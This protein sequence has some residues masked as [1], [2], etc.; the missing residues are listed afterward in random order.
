MES[1]LKRMKITI[2]TGGKSFL[3]RGRWLQHLQSMVGR[4]GLGQLVCGVSK[5]WVGRE[6][7]KS[8][9]Q[10]EDVR[11]Y[12]LAS[13]RGYCQC[14]APEFQGF[15]QLVVNSLRLLVRSSSGDSIFFFLDLQ[16][17]IFV[18][19]RGLLFL[20]SLCLPFSTICILCVPL[21]ST[22]QSLYLFYLSKN[23]IKKQNPSN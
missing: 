11:I 13:L 5:E 15:G 22:F 7:G 12:P 17:Y 20:F 14:H 18:L 21:P 1:N 4:S 3:L 10:V 16:G 2:W 6:S 19:D 8:V 23:K 9:K